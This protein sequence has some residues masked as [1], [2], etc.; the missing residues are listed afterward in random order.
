MALFVDWLNNLMM[1][2]SQTRSFFVLFVNL[3]IFMV[4]D[5]GSAQQ[6][7]IFNANELEGVC[8]NKNTA[9]GSF[10]STFSQNLSSPLLL[11]IF[12]G[13]SADCVVAGKCGIVPF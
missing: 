3:P 7:K 1:W 6:S 8:S 11:L 9:S 12:G 10:C 13:L 5:R 4:A 2:V